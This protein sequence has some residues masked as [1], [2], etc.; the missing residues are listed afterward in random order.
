MDLNRIKSALLKNNS[1]I[2][3]TFKKPQKAGKS[4]KIT[5]NKVTSNL[6]GEIIDK[7]LEKKSKKSL[8]SKAI[9][10]GN[11]NNKIKSS[12]SETKIQKGTKKN[13]NKKDLKKPKEI[14]KNQSSNKNNIKKKEIPPI[15][16][17]EYS[18]KSYKR[19]LDSPSSD[20]SKETTSTN[21][22]TVS[23][24]KNR[25]EELR[26]KTIN[27]EKESFF[28]RKEIKNNAKLKDVNTIDRSTQK[29]K[30]FI[31]PK[32]SKNKLNNFNPV[33]RRQSEKVVDIHKHILNM[34]LIRSFQYNDY[35]KH[36]E[37]KRIE[38]KNK[39]IENKVIRIQRVYR[40]F[41][42]RKINQILIRKKIN[43]C[44]IEVFCLLLN[45]AVNNYLKRE[46]FE[47]IKLYYHEPFCNIKEEMDIG[48]KINIRYNNGHYIFRSFRI[49]R[50]LFR[51]RI[52]RRKKIIKKKD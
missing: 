7:S 52:R 22:E 21:L 12:L 18:Q 23:A 34:R 41:V 13:T 33:S 8:F 37:K 4:R 51:K 29:K 26:V 48:D 31:Q 39:Y 46:Y 49:K 32:E 35:I 40:G 50:R 25:K 9:K 30:E 28:E 19:K 42:I 20:R 10:L 43:T 3:K 47:I 1:E 36:V 14:I 44:L 6:K 24:E 2:I 17:I 27:S 16:I 11:K 38:E 45:R 5:N 15:R